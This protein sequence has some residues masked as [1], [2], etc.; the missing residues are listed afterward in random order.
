MGEIDDIVGMGGR[1][2]DSRLVFE[3]SIREK[4]RTLLWLSASA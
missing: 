1:G 4:V 3:G 2:W